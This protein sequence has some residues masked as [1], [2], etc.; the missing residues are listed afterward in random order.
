[1]D[2]L[3]YIYLARPS[4]ATKKMSECVVEVPDKDS[5]ARNKI[6]IDLH[7]C[8]LQGVLRDDMLYGVQTT[9]K[10]EVPNGVLGVD[11]SSE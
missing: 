4:A 7:V 8:L 6:G 3:T 10:K 5:S 11:S 1:M 9:Q 2:I